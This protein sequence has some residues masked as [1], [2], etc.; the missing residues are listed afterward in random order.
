MRL[1]MSRAIVPTEKPESRA[2]LA[3][4]GLAAIAF[5]IMTI[6]AAW[7][8]TP[9]VDEC[10]HVPAGVAYWRH[11]RLDLCSTNPPLLKFWTALPIALDYSAVAPDVIESPLGW[12]PW[13]YGERFMNANRDQVLGLIFRS[14]LMVIALGLATGAIVFFWARGVFGLRA[15]SVCASLFLLCPNI[16][17]HS[18]LATIDM[19]SV[20]SITLGMFSLHWAY[21]EQTT[22][23][24]IV[25]GAAIGLALAIKFL[26]VLILPA[27]A[28]LVFMHRWL[29]RE[30]GPLARIGRS[31]FDLIL[32]AVVAVLVV[33]ASMGFQGSF[34]P[35][36]DYTLR[37][38]FG[39]T[40]A[41]HLPG[42]VFVPF[43]REYV[44]G[45]DAVKKVAEEGELGSYLMGEWSSKG[46]WYYNI[47]ALGVKLPIAL[48]V[49]VL[50]TPLFW[51]RSGVE[52]VDIA[53][54]IVPP[55][56]LLML[57]STF[58][59]ANIGVRHTL[60]ALPFAFILLGP[61]FM[62]TGPA[63]RRC[64]SAALIVVSIGSYGVNALRISPNF[65]TFFN[66]IAGGPDRGSQWLID[67]NLDWGQDLYRLPEELRE[68]NVQEPVYLL[69]F[70]HT[71]PSLYGIEYRLPPATPVAGVIAVS[72]NFLKG[73]P[74]VTVAPG[75]GGRMVGVKADAVAW[76]ADHEPVRK[77]GS[78]WVYDTRE[79]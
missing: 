42:W 5:L 23:S 2:W 68:L 45:F 38:Q 46:W 76:L 47:V 32:M 34:A 6:H 64:L 67:S 51:R 43:P 20:F 48:L 19:G 9:T 14:R 53:E 54:L 73:Y 25:A 35:L 65:L 1:T 62:S 74:Y 8:E 15:A 11:G 52:W 56:V 44:V 3:I 41:S 61:V 63:W 36:S 22:W 18:H 24:V 77:L 17:A 10:A 13:K 40:I 31:M 57:F 69:Y 75:T 30:R 50:V 39:L 37:S 28:V 26:A 72:V 66:V 29:D 21:K 58:N 12:G 55:V 33:N 60:P 27:V 79:Y 49:L 71:D 70:G 7:V 59:S 78:I 16:L 4:P